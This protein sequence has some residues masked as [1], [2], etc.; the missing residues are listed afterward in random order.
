MSITNSQKFN[1]EPSTNPP[2]GLSVEQSPQFV[3]IGFDDNYYPDGM[4]WFLDFMKDKRNADGSPAHVSFYVNTNNSF[5]IESTTDPMG[6]ALRK[7][8]LDAQAQGHEIGNHTAT[9]SFELR[10]QGK[11][12]WMADMAECNRQLAA[13]GIDM[14]KV[15]GFRTPF[16]R[17]NDA[18]FQASSELGFAYDCSIE[19][20]FND[21]EDGRFALWPYTLDNG[22]A[23]AD[24]LPDN[25]VKKYPGLWEFPVHA[26]V[27]PPQLR[28]AIA[29]RRKKA[30]PN[31]RFSES[32][33]KITGLDYDMWMDPNADQDPGL[34]GHEFLESLK[35]T[36]SQ[37]LKGKRAPMLFG[38]HTPLYDP[39][40]LPGPGNEWPHYHKNA[41]L[42]DMRKAL[43]DFVLHCLA[44]PQVR[45]VSQAELL[46]WMQAP[47]PL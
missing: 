32:F 7:A 14:S 47:K 44:I 4:N 37:R 45:L 30:D 40:T 42:A 31:T 16:L 11:A 39:L 2:G 15:V 43:E 3:C 38:A 5:D 26:V 36:L 8:W 20:G 41:S 1:V 10:N 6:P 12:E 21:D 25:P 28:K 29:E 22:P 24:F 34:S 18:T 19:S 23:P 13:I 35:Y 46:A 17:Y 9:H 27:V 33:G